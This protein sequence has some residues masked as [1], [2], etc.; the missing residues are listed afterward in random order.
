MLEFSVPYQ[1]AIVKT[2]KQ[3]RNLIKT[4]N[5]KKNLYR[6]VYH[7]D[8]VNGKPNF[9]NIV[10]NQLY[11]EFDNDNSHEIVKN[12]TQNF[13]K[14]GLKFRINFS[15]RRGYH[16]YILCKHENINRKSYLVQLH[17][18]VID[19]YNL[20]NDID[21]HVIGNIRQLRRIENTLN[22]RGNLYC[23]PI[24][25]QELQYL[26]FDEI[27]E[28]AE[29]PRNFD[30]CWIEG[31]ELKLD[32]IDIS[33]SINESYNIE[34]G[35][36]K[37]NEIKNILPEPCILRT[38]HLV[39][40]S[41]EERF[42]LCLWLSDKFRDGRNIND[43]DLDEL[44]EKIIIFM[45]TLNWDDYSEALGT[46]K[47]TRYQVNNIIGK[48]YNFVPNCDWRRMYGICNSEYCWKEKTINTIKTIK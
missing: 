6:S 23:I 35:N 33:N 5:G 17:K 26:T 28:I 31:N 7:F 32:N 16:I 41:Q 29:Q 18:Y 14:D 30:V 36:G 44:K 45:R 13:L 34:N 25:Y 21:H 27:K 40:P 42:L 8:I 11:I 39:H 22:I 15:G 9:N 48:R 38:L 2:I 46:S 43:F 4:W 1:R 3:Y 24:T 12:L 10:I 37:F 47:S 20:E 19:K